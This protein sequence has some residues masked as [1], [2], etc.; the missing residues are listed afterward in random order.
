M[1]TALKT[2]VVLRGMKR[3]TCTVRPKRRREEKRWREE[4]EK[5]RGEGRIGE[6]GKREGEKGKREEGGNGEE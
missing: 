4:G 2:E 6:K 5:R 3:V 1:G